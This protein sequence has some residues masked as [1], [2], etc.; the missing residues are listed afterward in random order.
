[1]LSVSA[2]SV[3]ELEGEF[4]GRESLGEESVEIADLDGP[5][6]PHQVDHHL[7]VELG[8]GLSVNRCDEMCYSKVLLF[9]TFLRS[10]IKY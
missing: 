1:M 6:E 2:V 3:V 9:P 5:V 7:R 10:S 8:Q 4:L